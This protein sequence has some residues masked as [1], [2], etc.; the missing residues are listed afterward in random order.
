MRK[1]GSDWSQAGTLGEENTSEAVLSKSGH[2]LLSPFYNRYRKSF[3]PTNIR[4]FNC[5]YLE[6]ILYSAAL[7]DQR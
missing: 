6:L 4:I 7:L 3:V 1:A 5:L 2:P